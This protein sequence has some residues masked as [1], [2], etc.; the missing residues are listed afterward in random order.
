MIV[1]YNSCLAL[2]TGFRGGSVGEDLRITLICRD[3]GGSRI[4]NGGFNVTIYITV[5][6]CKEILTQALV[7][8]NTDG[9]YNCVYR[10]PEKRGSYELHIKIE[11]NLACGSPCPIFFNCDISDTFLRSNELRS[12]EST[13]YGY[14]QPEQNQI[15]EKI[16]EFEIHECTQVAVNAALTHLNSSSR[17]NATMQ[18]EYNFQTAIQ[19]ALTES[20]YV[21]ALDI[22]P[23]VTIEELKELFSFYGKIESLEFKEDF[24]NYHAL[25]KFS[26]ADEAEKSLEAS[27]IQVGDRD[28]R[29]EKWVEHSVAHN[30]QINIL[31]THLLFNSKNI[32]PLNLQN[33]PKIDSNESK[34]DPKIWKKNWELS[35]L[36]IISKYINTVLWN[37]MLPLL[38]LLSSKV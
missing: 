19:Q 26:T 34:V 28:L 15:S 6:N 10:S 17:F 4:N 32:S 35:F 38:Q 1:D 2:G 22:S 23:L 13:C 37:N 9:T 21:K 29:V 27:G 30:I 33:I 18:F 5:S 36:G 16:S 14:D 25:I 31:S 11:K 24:G 8:D 20:T 3:F 12:S 7:T